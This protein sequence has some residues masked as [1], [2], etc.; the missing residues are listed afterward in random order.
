MNQILE[1]QQIPLTCELWGVYFDDFGE[2]W[3]RYNGTALYLTGYDHIQ[4]LSLY[5]IIFL[6]VYVCVSL[7]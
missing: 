1:S 5:V 6:C 7:A 2:N 3:P 4:W